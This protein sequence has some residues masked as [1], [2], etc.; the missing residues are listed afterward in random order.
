MRRHNKR[1]LVVRGFGQKADVRGLA[2]RG[3]C[4]PSW[5][6]GVI[7]HHQSLREERTSPG[8]PDES[9]PRTPWPVARSSARLGFGGDDGR[10]DGHG[11]TTR[12][13]GLQ[14]LTPTA[15]FA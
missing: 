6:G 5:G 2:A 4:V 13:G 9:V 11:E 1:D 10:A 8:R 12:Y 15:L 14:D 7:C 3:P